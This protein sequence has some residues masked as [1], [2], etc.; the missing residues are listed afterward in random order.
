MLPTMMVMQERVMTTPMT[1]LATSTGDTS[2]W[3]CS[4][5]SENV[6]G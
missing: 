1:A 5:L 6:V 2:R 4:E 3:L